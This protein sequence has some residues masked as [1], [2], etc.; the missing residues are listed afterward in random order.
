MKRRRSSAALNP[1]PSHFPLAELTP[2]MQ[3][4]VLTHLPLLDLLQGVARTSRTLCELA[5]TELRH[6]LCRD[7]FDRV[8]PALL[9]VMKTTAKK[10]EEPWVPLLCNLVEMGGRYFFA[11]CDSSGTLAK[12]TWMG[13]A[14][15]LTG[16]TRLVNDLIGQPGP[17]TIR[18][19]SPAR[20]AL[21]NSRTRP[22]AWYWSLKK[23]LVDDFDILA[24]GSPNLRQQ[25]RRISDA[26]RAV[27]RASDGLNAGT[28]EI[29]S[30]AAELAT[31][32]ENLLHVSLIDL[33]Y[34]LTLQYGGGLMGYATACLYLQAADYTPPK[35]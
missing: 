35:T 30:A 19:F 5:Q 27:N 9:A 17:A 10:E 26:L 4:T 18:A 22:V 16:A 12:I 23:N 24:L 28:D 8:T 2:E 20:H 21:N 34:D 32:L 31:A 6:R 25:H 13:H 29:E 3:A 11:Q 1:M 33:G 15:W 14:W 7:V